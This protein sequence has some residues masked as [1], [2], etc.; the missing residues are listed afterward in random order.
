MQTQRKSARVTGRKSSEVK[1]QPGVSQ[2]LDLISDALS[3]GLSPVA[4]TSVFSEF[5]GF[6]RTC[7]DT[8]IHWIPRI[9]MEGREPTVPM[10]CPLSS[11]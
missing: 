7:T 6:M 8:F 11:T 3:L 2:A 10:S 9:N 5:A 1:E 4:S